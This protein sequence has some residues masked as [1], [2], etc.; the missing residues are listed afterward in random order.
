MNRL[1]IAQRIWTFALVAIIAL[2]ATI[3][4]ET[5]NKKNDILAAKEETTRQLVEMAHSYFEHYHDLFQ[6]GEMTEA[7]AKSAALGAIRALRYAGSGYFWVNDTTPRLVMHPFKPQ[8]EGKDM[9]NSTDANGKY[10]WREFV[11]ATRATGEGSVFYAYK[12]PQFDK[13][14]AKLSYLKAFEPWG[15]IVGS[16]IYIDDVDEQFRAL[17]VKRGLI[18]GAVVVLFALLALLLARSIN[19][20][21]AKTAEAM[22]EIAHG[23]GDLRVRMSTQG[24]CELARLGESFNSFADSVRGVVSEVTGASGELAQAAETMAVVSEQSRTALAT[25]RQESDLIVTAVEEMSSTIDSVAGSAES[26][27]DQVQQAL[28]QAQQ[29]VSQVGAS[30]ASIQQLA[31]AVEEAVQRIN[32]LEE[33]SQNIGRILEVISEIAEQTN[34]LALNAAIE[35][36]RAGEQGRGFAVVAD[37][38]RSLA[39]RTQGATTEIQQLID[40]LQSGAGGA[41]Q[42]IAGG[43]TLAAD[44]VTQSE[45]VGAAL[46][47]IAT[48]VQSAA[49]INLEIASVTGEQRQAMAS[50]SVNVSNIHEALAETSEGS[51]QVT[52]VSQ[53]LRETGQRISSLLERFKV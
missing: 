52:E 28:V 15:W 5:L 49:A 53:Q 45:Q 38:V 47:Q 27:A 20:P 23:N 7:D 43:R 9:R 19:R 46:E 33:E 14:K 24:A 42:T 1:S 16:G 29:G 8:L 13:P 17:V 6:A 11:S 25:H 35:A 40:Q 12:G 30:I 31:A 18:G 10:H 26:A 3:G 4:M 22:E 50:I 34:L 51:G 37:E 36:A 32:T 21:L 2:A 41:V 48:K 39:Q 44:S